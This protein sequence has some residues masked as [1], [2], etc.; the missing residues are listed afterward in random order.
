MKTKHWWQLHNRLVKR[1][2]KA[3]NWKTKKQR[4]EYEFLLWELAEIHQLMLEI[5]LGYE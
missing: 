3:R 1:V 4:R 5:L 2:D